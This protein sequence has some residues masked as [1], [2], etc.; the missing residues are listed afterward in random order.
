MLAKHHAAH[1]EGWDTHLGLVAVAYNTSLHDSTGFAPFFSLRDE[2][3]YGF[4]N[5]N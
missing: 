5:I 2:T 4:T 1:P 3:V